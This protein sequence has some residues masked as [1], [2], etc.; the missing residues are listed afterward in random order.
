M[1][2]ETL[3]H[4]D[5][6]PAQVANLTSRAAAA[7]WGNVGLRHQ[8]WTYYAATLTE[9]W[10]DH[11]A[12]IHRN[13][14]PLALVL[15]Q[16]TGVHLGY[17]CQPLIFAFAPGVSEDR[18][19]LEA[20]LLDHC[21]AVAR[22]HRLDLSLVPPRRPGTVLG[23]AA[24]ALA[25]RG[26]VCRPI[27]TG[28]VPLDR[29]ESE[30]W[31]GLRKSYRPLINWGRRHLTL[32]IVDGDHPDDRLFADFQAFHHRVAGRQTRPQASWDRMLD[33]IHAGR[34]ELI[35]GH[36]EGD[37]LS[38]TFINHGPDEAS[39]ATGV[40]DRTAFDKPLGHWPVYA[41][42]LRARDRGCR[43]FTLGPV[44]LDHQHNRKERDIGFFK[45]GFTDQVEADSIW[46]LPRAK[47]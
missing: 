44:F 46:S 43:R 9:P 45:K 18:D 31:R 16:Q 24:L 10:T 40:Y 25:G 21:L 3:V 5:Q 22:Q 8:L 41:A 34:A 38:A 11:S 29:P 19:R 4:H 42:I 12:V 30:L 13:G 1:S 26:A 36:L 33:N 28:F 27:F 7:G 14:E 17:F 47:L 37:L 32:T 35:T 15:A 23:P 6:A 2:I 39:Y 20:R